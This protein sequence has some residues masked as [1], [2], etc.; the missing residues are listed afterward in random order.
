MYQVTDPVYNSGYSNIVLGTSATCTATQ[1]LSG[2][3]PFVNLSFNYQGDLL[4]ALDALRSLVKELDN[5]IA[6]AFGNQAGGDF[7]TYSRSFQVSGR[8]ENYSF[9]A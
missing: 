5:E 2:R 8:S 3:K 7:A 6:T 4:S 9:G 1:A